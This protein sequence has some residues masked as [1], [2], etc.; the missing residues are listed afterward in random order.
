MSILDTNT[1][2][3][4]HSQN[5]TF[6]NEAYSYIDNKDL[7]I[8]KPYFISCDGVDDYFSKNYKYLPVFSHP[9]V[10]SL[11]LFLLI[12]NETASNAENKSD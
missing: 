2:I 11:L 8:Y 5:K 7:N 3:G 10:L 9:K 1:K 12:L 6:L 4:K